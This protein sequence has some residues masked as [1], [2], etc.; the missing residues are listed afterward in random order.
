MTDSTGSFTINPSGPGAI[1][2]TSVS[3]TECTATSGITISFSTKVRDAVG[4]FQEMVVIAGSGSFTMTCDRTQ[5]V[6]T[7]TGNYVLINT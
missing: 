7:L 1:A 4:G 3:N 2:G 5:L 6:A